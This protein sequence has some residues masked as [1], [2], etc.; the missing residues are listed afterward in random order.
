MYFCYLEDQPVI[1][2][3]KLE[4]VLQFISILFSIITYLFQACQGRNLI[5]K[6]IFQLTLLIKS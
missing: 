5:C 6:D 1:A 3:W 2:L 4:T